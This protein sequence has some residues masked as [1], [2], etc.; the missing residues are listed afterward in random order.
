MLDKRKIFNI[1]AFV[2]VFVVGYG[3]GYGVGRE[4]LSL[5]EKR[6]AVINSV[7]DQA[8]LS[9]E[10]QEWADW[11]ETVDEMDNLITQCDTVIDSW[12]GRD[13]AKVD[14]IISYLKETEKLLT[15]SNGPPDA[16]WYKDGLMANAKKRIEAFELMKTGIQNNSDKTLRDASKLED[17]AI[18]EFAQLT[19][20][21]D[22]WLKD[23][24]Y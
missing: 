6:K 15:A 20:K 10:E 17:E 11:E 22:K 9:S 19:E 18:A 4:D 23:N 7:L 16:A 14:E 5:V 13:T 1:I 2:L 21:Y 24:G 3:L 12:D 8:R